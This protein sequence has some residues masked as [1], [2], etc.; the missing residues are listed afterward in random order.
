MRTI[1]TKADFDAIIGEGGERLLL[2]YSAWCPFCTSFLPIF[3]KAAAANPAAFAEVC[4][5][6]LPML[7][8]IFSIEVV[9]TALYFKD[10]SLK[11]RLDGE[12]GLGLNAENLDA[13]VRSSG[14]AGKKP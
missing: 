5:D 7:E 13:F 9:P 6:D 12:L 4:V 8:D 3:K 2:F 11:S 10:K 1:K 14:T